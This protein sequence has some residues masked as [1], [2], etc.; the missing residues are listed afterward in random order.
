M[1]S[2]PRFGRDMRVLQATL[3]GEV[4]EDEAFDLTLVLPKGKGAPP[5]TQPQ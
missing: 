4:L 2:V 1:S 5:L 3:R